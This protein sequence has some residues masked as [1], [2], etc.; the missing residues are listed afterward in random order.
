MASQSPGNRPGILN[1]A[2]IAA[3]ALG[4]VLSASA[5]ATAQKR[6]SSAI[7]PGGKSNAPIN[8]NA[9]RLDFLDKE[10]KL[11]YSG[12]VVARQGD[13][14]LKCS[15]L[16]IFLAK[17]AMKNAQSGAANSGDQVERMEA[18]GPV[19][20][21]SKDQVGTGNHGIFDKRKNVVYLI[22]NP[23]LTQGSNI[24][25]GGATARLV[26]DL[27]SGRARIS[28]GRVTS[29]IVPA[30]KR[31]PAGSRSSNRR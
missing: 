19:I 13:A 10:S 16:T 11:V 17:G 3:L 1:L 27:T 29:V 26:Y 14:T 8:I 18:S 21:S 15:K 28:G 22:G 24:T 7:I 23:V 25:K 2:A 6:T 5:P 9:G 12:G 4:L 20:I 30:G 31:P